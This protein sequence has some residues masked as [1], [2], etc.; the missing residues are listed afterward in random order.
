M[1]KINLDLVKVVILLVDLEIFGKLR[2]K[3]VTKKS[4]LV[5]F[6]NFLIWDR[7]KGDLKKVKIYLLIWIFPL[8]RQ[9]KVLKKKLNLKK[10]ESALHA[11]EINAS[12]V[13]PQQNVP[14]VEVEEK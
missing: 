6:H 14:L 13:R 11:V 5:I 12:P 8:W 2:V 4:F 9:Y 1:N 3:V 7:V 10:K